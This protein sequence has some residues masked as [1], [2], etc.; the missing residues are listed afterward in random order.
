M[1]YQFPLNIFAGKFQII[2]P[3]QEEIT[4]SSEN[5]KQIQETKL[6][7]QP[8]KYFQVNNKKIEFK[9]DLLL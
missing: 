9:L 4:F 3:G 8:R 6:I 2:E 1:S 5:G 7:C